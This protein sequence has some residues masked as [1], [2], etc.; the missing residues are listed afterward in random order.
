MNDFSDT[1][2]KGFHFLQNPFLLKYI[3]IYFI[4]AISSNISVVNDLGLSIA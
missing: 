2:K 1:N 4:P 3:L